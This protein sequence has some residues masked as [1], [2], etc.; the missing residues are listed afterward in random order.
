MLFSPAVGPLFSPAVVA[1]FI[2]VVSSSLL[3]LLWSPLCSRLSGLVSASRADP[4]VHHR[5]FSH[6]LR[7]NFTSEAAHNTPSHRL[8]LAEPPHA[9]LRAT[10]GL[11]VPSPTLRKTSSPSRHCA[12]RPVIPELSWPPCRRHGRGFC[13]ATCGTTFARRWNCLV[14][15]VCAWNVCTQTAYCT[16]RQALLCSASRDRALVCSGS[17]CSVV[18]RVK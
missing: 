18:I 15:G 9:L 13:R 11:G 6:V 8:R 3:V 14:V 17:S 5:T 4:R 1:L 10:R 16:F 2:P 12:W 7:Q